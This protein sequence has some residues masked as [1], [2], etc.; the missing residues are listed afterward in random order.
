[1]LA[2]NPE[3]GIGDIPLW[4]GL[5]IVLIT[6][7]TLFQGL[8][9][10]IIFGEKNLLIALTFVLTSFCIFFLLKKYL[11]KHKVNQAITLSIY[12]TFIIDL[13]LLTVYYMCQN[14]SGMA[15]ATTTMILVIITAFYTWN[16]HLQV[17]SMTEQ[18]DLIRSQNKKVD[19]HRMQQ[20]HANL[21]GKELE[22]LDLYMNLIQIRGYYIA[23][24]RLIY[25]DTLKNND[26]KEIAET[27]F[28]RYSE[29]EGKIL[30]EIIRS[31]G[32]LLETLNMV[33]LLAKSTE[34]D[35]S[36]ELIYQNL[37]SLKTIFKVYTDKSSKDLDCKLDKKT[38]SITIKEFNEIRDE[39]LEKM[40]EEIKTWL[41]KNIAM[42]IKNVSQEFN[43]EIN[44]I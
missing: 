37:S 12:G 1:M 14:N 8:R 44:K 30:I 35:N 3:V 16:T 7:I 24:D 31:N 5:S 27:E 18:A 36:I 11:I 38:T 9:D 32:R 19:K 25:H 6:L 42:M 17:E 10:F 39:L 13:I 2:L 28:K 21:K 26:D 20:A 15:T 41:D 40:N 22:F 29:E 23:Y 43:N 4:I 33:Q 34:I